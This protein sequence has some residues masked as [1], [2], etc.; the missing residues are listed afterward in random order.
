MGSNVLIFGRF[1]AS[2]CSIFGLI[3]YETFLRPLRAK[4]TPDINNSLK[5]GDIGDIEYFNTT[6]EEYK[7]INPDGTSH[8]I[9]KDEFDGVHVIL[10]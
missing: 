3:F 7:V 2:K 10:L 5:L 8:Y 9:T 6:L 1:S 4:I